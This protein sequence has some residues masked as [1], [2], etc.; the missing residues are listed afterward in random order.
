MV[1][2]AA[3][4]MIEHWRRVGIVVQL[5]DDSLD[6]ADNQWDLVYCT[7]KVIE[8]LTEIWP[9]LTM[10]ADASVESL[11]PLPERVRR[12][13]L[14]LERTSDWPSATKRLH[15]IETELLLETRFI[16]LWEVDEFFVTR[17]HLIGLPPSLMHSFHDVERWKLQS[18]YPQDNP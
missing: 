3:T 11:R 8:P 10:K 14:E 15:R 5:N 1:R 17:R 6:S 9:L 2:A 12:Q 4:E 16:P 18:W 7:T 13:L